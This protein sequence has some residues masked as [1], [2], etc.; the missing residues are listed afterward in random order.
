MLP[1]YV[2][3]CTG[4]SVVLS[5]L[6]SSSLAVVV[7]GWNI[8]SILFMLIFRRN[9]DDAVASASLILWISS[10]KWEIG[11]LSAAKS[12]TLKR[13]FVFLSSL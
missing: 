12:S 7:F 1:R 8:T 6:M 2:N 9:F 13:I 3:Y 11:A 4:F 10:V 5:T